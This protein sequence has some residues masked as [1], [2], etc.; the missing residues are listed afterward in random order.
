MTRAMQAPRPSGR[1]A[2]TRDGRKAALR[3]GTAM[4]LVMAASAA[5]AQCAGLSGAVG[6][7]GGGLIG[8]QVQFV[9]QTTISGVQSLVSVLTTQNTAFLTQ[10]SGFIGAPANPSENLQGGGVWARG[11]GGT[12]DTKTPGAYGTNTNPLIFDGSPQNNACNVRTFQDY[13]GFQT[14]ADISRLNVNG[15][16]IHGGVTMGYTESSVRSTSGFRA[17][18]Q[19][20]FVGIYG[21]VTKGSFFA[22]GQVRWD[23]FQGVLNDPTNTLTNQRLDA[24]S[25]SLTGNVGYQFGLNDGWFVEPSAGAVYSE[26]KV[27]RLQNGGEFLVASSPGFSFPSSVK[28]QD[29]DSILARASLR[30]GKNIIVDGYALQPFFTASVINEFA[31]PVRTNLT[32]DFGSLGGALG[33]A[34][35]IGAAA[36]TALLSPYD[37]RVRLSTYRIGT[38]GQF[39]VGIAGQILNTGWLGYVRGDYRTGDRVEGW[40]VSGGL[41]Y[42]FN[43]EAAARAIISKDA[44]PLLAPLD[45]PV[46]WTGFSAGASVGGLWSQTRQDQFAF[47]SDILDRAN[48]HAA[49]VYAGGQIGADY[50]FGRIVVGVAG[51]AGFTNARG[52]SGCSAGIGGNFFNCQTNI[53]D[54]YMATARVGYAMERSLFYVKGGAAFADTSEKQQNN[55]NDRA[56]L[57]GLP[58]FTGSSV[59]TFSTG[60]TVGGGFEYAITRN[61]SAKAEYMHFELDRKAYA[62]TPTNIAFVTAQHTGDLVKI[63][64]NYRFTFDAP[65]PVAPVRAVIAK[66]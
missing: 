23:F 52:G 29:F 54:L 16:N 43:P 39:S 31:A 40:G 47:F 59:K 48:P 4:L 42:Q 36:G 38:Y 25:L 1:P 37:S 63:G 26:A 17:D 9:P 22:D 50:Q 65:A 51:D 58:S 12:F 15:F 11:I 30:I 45:S 32:T 56:L 49:G 33:Q 28:I 64:V 19:T 13:A 61:W 46:T 5:H 27:D 2:Q 7:G 14:G 66:Y 44:A 18:F 34:A 55:F 57:F 35:G 21:A 10:T 24:R 60:W 41:R 8:G 6:G 62:F 20:P 3:G 53:D